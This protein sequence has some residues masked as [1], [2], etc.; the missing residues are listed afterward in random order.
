MIRNLYKFE[1]LEI[2]T[3][4]SDIYMKWCLLSEGV[5]APVDMQRSRYRCHVRNRKSNVTGRKTIQNKAII[6]YHWQFTVTL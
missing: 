5:P 3:R 4:L 6:M 2:T 1:A